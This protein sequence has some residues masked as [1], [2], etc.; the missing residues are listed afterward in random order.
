MSKSLIVALGLGLSTLAGA[1]AAQTAAAPAAPAAAAPAASGALTTDS[2]VQDLAANPAAKAVLD[3]NLPMLTSHEA[4]E[5]FKMMSLKE[6]Q[7]LSGGI[8]TDEALA[9]IQADLAKL[10]KA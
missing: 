2:P 8:I 3:A 1:A 4:Y 10:P 6:L 5:S 7:P 9:K